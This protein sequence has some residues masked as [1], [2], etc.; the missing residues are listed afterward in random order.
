[1]LVKLPFVHVE[2]LLNDVE[3]LY[4]HF[5]NVVLIVEHVDELFLMLN[6]NVVLIVVMVM[7]NQYL[8]LHLSKR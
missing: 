2:E 7:M 4:S 1:V 5:S 8:P 6:L 3:H